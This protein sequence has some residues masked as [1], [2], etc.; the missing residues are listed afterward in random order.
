MK[1]GR[2]LLVLRLAGVLPA[3][4][5]AATSPA[6]AVQQFSVYFTQDSAELTQAA[7]A[8]IAAAATKFRETPDSRAT[9]EG[10]TDTLGSRWHNLRLS[11]KRSR[12]VSHAL[13]ALGVP[14]ARITL[15]WNGET[16]LPHPTADSIYEPLNR[17]VT[18]NV[19][20]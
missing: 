2:S 18:I 3:L 17:T 8:V 11:K 7:Q 5:L 1:L 4:T 9:L 6:V 14:K 12:S 20:P 13:R 19:K 16:N 10:H 15:R